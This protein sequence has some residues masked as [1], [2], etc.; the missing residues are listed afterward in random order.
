MNNNKALFFDI[1]GTLFDGQSKSVLPSTIKL[2][3]L[4]SQNKEYDL[5]LS[6]GRSLETLG[7]MK[8]YLHYFDG[9][10]LSNGQE[11]IIG[12]EYV[13]EGYIDKE[14]IKR[15]LVKSVEKNTPLGLIT[16]EE[17]VINFTTDEG[18]KYFT[19]YIK[20]DVKIL[21]D[22]PFD[23][24][25]RVY[26]VWLFANNE[27]VEEYQKEFP[28]LDIIKW[29]SYG[30]D[31]IPINASK[32]NGIKIIQKLKD[33]PKENMY[34]FGD[35]D[36]DVK[37]FKVVGTS[38]AMGQGSEKAKAA[39]SFITDKIDEDGLYKAIIKLGLIKEE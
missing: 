2:L 28:N 17:I 1:D 26:Q 7:S 4:L 31:V 24:E 25:R 34:A 19:T 36:N 9:L 33:Y 22:E 35:G 21:N 39:A 13:Y 18:T 38:V 20:P 3:E 8:N 5:Y 14:E 12:N 11:I 37:M 10:N 32:A 23:L 6:T 30:A 15:L 27:L 29:G 16:K